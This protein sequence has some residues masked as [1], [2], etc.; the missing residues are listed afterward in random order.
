MSVPW[1]K[2]KK[3]IENFETV[4]VACSGGADSMFLLDFVKGC[5]VNFSVVHFNH[6]MRKNAKND[7]DFVR[8][9][10]TQNAMDERLYVG[11]GVDISNEEQARN[12]R[13]AFLKDIMSS[14]GATRI[15]TGHH[16]ND[17]AETI[18]L[19]LTRGY[20]H[21]NLMMQKDNGF[22]YRPF[23]DI[24][25][26]VILRQVEHRKIEHIVDE[27]NF[28]MDHER[29]RIRHNVIPELMKT[30]N[31]MKALQRGIRETKWT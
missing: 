23:L 16:F 3:E 28:S 6:N 1:K 10:C 31:V 11:Y 2:I 19:R 29:N 18:L 22:V 24:D 4:V 13:Y 8:S 7:E 14:V 21:N 15:L 30:R 25:Q 26:A 17:Q 12:Q 27:S 9:Y 20:P 5:N